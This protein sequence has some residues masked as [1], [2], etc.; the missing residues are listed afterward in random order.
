MGQR[1]VVPH[2][3]AQRRTRFSHFLTVMEK[4]DGLFQRDS[5]EQV[6]D[7]CLRCQ[8]WQSSSWAL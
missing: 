5:D 7:D 8:V 4:L 6:D 3:F 2:F 1:D